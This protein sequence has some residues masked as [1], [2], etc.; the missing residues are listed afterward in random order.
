[1][2]DEEEETGVIKQVPTAGTTLLG[3]IRFI[4]VLLTSSFPYFFRFLGTA[5]VDWSVS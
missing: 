4:L 2:E 1:M 5:V 3:D